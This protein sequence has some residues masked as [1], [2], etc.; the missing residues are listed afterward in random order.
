[1][2]FDDGLMIGMMLGGGGGS[3]GGD[4]WAFP[5]HWPDIPDPEPNQ[6]IMYIEAEDGDVAPIIGLYG[7]NY[8]GGTIDY[9][10]D[11]TYN[12]PEGRAYNVYHVYQTAGQYIIT[13]NAPDGEVEISYNSTNVKFMD[14]S[15]TEGNYGGYTSGKC[16]C[17]KA[18]K[19]GGNIS[20]NNV[21]GGYGGSTAIGSYYQNCLIYIEYMG[22]VN[23]KNNPIFSNFPFLKKIKIGIPP[24]SFGDGAF[25]GDSALEIADCLKNC[26][27]ITKNMFATCV[28]L[29]RVD[30]INATS[31]AGMAFGYCF[32][33]RIVNAPNLTQLASG[34]FY[35]CYSLQKLILAEGCDYNGNT[36][37]YSPQLYPKTQ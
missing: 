25:S 4:E 31:Q 28:S 35:Y 33:L 1:M 37:A 22:A 5:E 34:D 12:Y 15:I 30:M 29:R 17:L 23:D 21:A 10:D 2:S 14:G 18:I 9:G 16:Q 8:G 13:I 26:T 6:V 36:F 3:G 32:N 24:D 19:I 11:G 7:Q 27:S 20:L